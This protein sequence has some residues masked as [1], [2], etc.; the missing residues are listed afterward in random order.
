MN[1]LLVEDDEDTSSFV[2]YVLEQ[3][4]HHVRTAATIA[5]ARERLTESAPDLVIL[6]RALPDEDGLDF[7]RELK[8][9]AEFADVPVLFLSAQRDPAEVAEGLDSGGDDYVTKPF[10]FVELV[11]R[12]QALLRRREKGAR[13]SQ[14]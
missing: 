12:V 3:E 10:G 13:F 11:A 14:A 9:S 4:S 1:L 6:D 5:E 2:K 7:C 8:K